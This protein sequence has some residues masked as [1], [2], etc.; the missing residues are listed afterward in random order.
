MISL[1]SLGLRL[2]DTGTWNATFWLG[3]FTFSAML[4]LV[5]M[6]TG[7]S[8]FR[9]AMAGG[10]PLAT[11]AVFT[12][13]SISMF[14]VAI[15]L[16][17]VANTVAIIAAAPVM[18]ALISLI[19]IG[20]R[21]RARTWVGIFASIAGI[22]VIVSGSLGEGRIA[23]DLSA[24]AAIIIFGSNLTLLRRYPELNR[25]VII[26]M[27][28]LAMAIIAAWPAEPFEV[29]SSSI[30]VLA[31][32]GLATSPAGRIAVITSTRYLPPAQV[33]LFAPVETIAATAWAWLFLSETP[34]PI[35]IVGAVIVVAAVVYGTTGQ[36]PEAT[37]DLAT[38]P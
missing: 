9:A 26:G 10:L 16:T 3:V 38:A 17:T 33:S 25:L 7:D 24:V 34:P 11:S 37:G 21:T 22:L 32:L 5:P 8:L 6:R 14:V 12:A 20:E 4:V 13:G 35:T 19:A 23:G 28:G 2:A 27:G 15:S 30:L 29:D 18:A 36:S 31:V 1:D